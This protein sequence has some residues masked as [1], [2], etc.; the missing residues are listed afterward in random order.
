M[1]GRRFSG[2]VAIRRDH[3]LVMDGLCRSIRN[4]SDLGLPVN[5]LVWSLAFRSAVGV[6]IA[7]LLIPP[8]IARAKAEEALPSRHFGAASEAYCAGAWRL[9]L[10]ID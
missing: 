10:F 4:P 5:S 8:L 1:L 3:T 6:V 2:L 9:V 7:A